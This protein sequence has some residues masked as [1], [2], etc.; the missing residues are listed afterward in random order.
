[1]VRTLLI[2]NDAKCMAEPINER[3]YQVEPGHGEDQ[4]GDVKVAKRPELAQR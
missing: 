3:V 2:Q 1:M 4:I